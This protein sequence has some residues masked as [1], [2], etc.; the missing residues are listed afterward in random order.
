[1]PPA[2]A[3]TPLCLGKRSSGWG[4]YMPFRGSLDEVVITQILPAPLP[5]IHA[6][7]ENGQIII[8]WTGCGWLEWAPNIRGPWQAVPNPVRPYVV[9][10]SAQRA[11]YRL[12]TDTD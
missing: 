10:P 4:G 8:S 1:M 12:R 2:A 11:F 3:A 5:S 7:L 6:R 9:S